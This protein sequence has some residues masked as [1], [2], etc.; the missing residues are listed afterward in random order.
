LDDRAA[1]WTPPARVLATDSLRVF[2]DVRVAHFALV[3]ADIFTLDGKPLQAAPQHVVDPAE[4]FAEVAAGAVQRRT[5]D[6]RRSP[7]APPLP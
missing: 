5:S 7:D 1:E 3:G 6:N 2:Y 4:A